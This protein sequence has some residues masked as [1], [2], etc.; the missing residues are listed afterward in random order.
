[1]EPK[2]YT[3]LCIH[4]N[5]N[6]ILDF[7]LKHTLSLNPSPLEIIVLDDGSDVKPKFDDPRVRFMYFDHRENISYMVNEGVLMLK[8]EYFII[9]TSKMLLDTK[10]VYLSFLVY[11]EKVKYTGI[12]VNVKNYR[13][14]PELIMTPPYFENLVIPDTIPDY[15]PLGPYLEHIDNW[16]WYNEA[17]VGYGYED[18]DYYYRWAINGGSTIRTNCLIFYKYSTSRNSHFYTSPN[19]N[20]NLIDS[21]I[22]LYSNGYKIIFNKDNRF[23]DPRIK[24]N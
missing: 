7:N 23:Y 12:M 2:P 14:L 22:L 24:Q 17:Y 13:E 20:K 9:I 8:T 11:Q 19:D 10:F 18:V 16:V 21:L 4:Y 5:Q 1:M 6:E 15:H 3:I